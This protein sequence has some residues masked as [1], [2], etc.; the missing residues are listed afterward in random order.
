MILA[1]Q[2]L[3]SIPGRGRTG[4]P[5][6][7]HLLVRPRPGLASPAVEFPLSPPDIVVIRGKD[8]TWRNENRTGTYPMESTHSISM[9]G[10]ASMGITV[11]LR[12]MLLVCGVLVAAPVHATVLHAGS[13]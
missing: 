1:L 3:P 13:A 11:L 12:V 6:P 7:A 10:S 8:T 9:E 5:Y 4:S 2:L